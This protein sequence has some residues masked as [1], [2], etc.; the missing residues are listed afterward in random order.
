V[1]IRVGVLGLQGDYQ[2]HVQ[3]LEHLGVAVRLVR[4]P[5]ALTEVQGLIIPGGES[6]TIGKLMQRFGL[7]E[8][9]RKRAA[10]GMPVFG[11]C[12]G[13]ILLAREILGPDQPRLGLMDIAVERNAYGRQIESFEVDL[14]DGRLASDS[15]QTAGD[16]EPVRAAPVRG[17]FIRAPIIRRLGE[18]CAP[19]LYYGDDPVV[20]Q[21]GPHLIATFHPE[22]VGEPRVHRRFLE[23]IRSA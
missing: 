4:T 1:Q 19:L 3:L 5:E 12:A 9:A 15:E 23:L 18:N 2:R 13:A 14:E 8:I 6:T 22:L 17:V 20:V 21:E 10:D 16:S 11:T 7:L